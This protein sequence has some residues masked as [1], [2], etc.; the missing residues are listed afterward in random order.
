MSH[1]IKMPVRYSF[2]ENIG[3]SKI[4]HDTT[5]SKQTEK[6]LQETRDELELKVEERNAELRKLNALF[7][8][9]DNIGSPIRK[10]VASIGE[11]SGVDRVNLFLFNNNNQREQ[12][13]T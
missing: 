8:A 4:E 11:F 7:S 2:N 6:K 5:G 13:L 9:I 1:V 12:F 10:V 3:T